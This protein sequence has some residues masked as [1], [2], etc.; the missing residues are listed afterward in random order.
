[1]THVFSCSRI[2]FTSFARRCVDETNGTTN[3]N[4]KFDADARFVG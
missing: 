3:S 2:D 4:D 1:M